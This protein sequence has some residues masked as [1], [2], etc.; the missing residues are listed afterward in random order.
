MDRS[1]GDTDVVII[2][3]GPAGLTAAYE[4]SKH[5]I[6]GVILEADSVVG[7]IART[8]ERNGYRFD[9]GG[10]RFFSKS[11]EIEALWD[12]MLPGDM[13]TRPRL[14]RI[15]YNGKFYDYPLRASNA[16]KN[17]GLFTALA[18]MSSYGL[19][20][21]R[22]IPNPSN[23]EEWVTNQ[24]GSK[25]YHMFFQTY[26]EK[27]WGIPCTEIGA[28]W[29]AQR[30]KGLSLAEAVRNAVFGSRKGKVVKTLVD[31]FRYPQLGPGQLWQACADAVVRQ[32]WQLMMNTRATGIRTEDG[33][34][35][36]VVV[37]DADGSACELSCRNVISGMPI[38]DL[39]SAIDNVPGP[40]SDAAAELAYRDFLTVAL[41]LDKDELFPDNWIY[42]HSPQVKLGRIQNF[43]NWSPDLVPDAAKTCLG[44]EYF[45]NEGDELWCADD[46][47]LVALGYSELSSIG[48]AGGKMLEGYVVRMPKAYPVYNQAY[49]KNMDS[50]RDWLKSVGGLQCVGRNGQHRYNNMDHSMMTALLAARNVADPSLRMDPWAVNEDAEYH[51]TKSEG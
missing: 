17:M 30:I 10:H 35:C 1:L 43:K 39:V 34:V 40:V 26:T 50:I 49:D 16:L 23:L 27:V 4:L 44:L 24:F 11:D 36:A 5:G 45:C 46:G 7:G 51:E 28:D 21:I 37:Q 6:Q 41:V 20:R 38:R 13:L 8:E 3:A 12:E 9:I 42:V 29:A 18:C 14:S 19:A 47:D 33:R 32:G 48:L 15:H 2:G 25:L 22:P 31:Q